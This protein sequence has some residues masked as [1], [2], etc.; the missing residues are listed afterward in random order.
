MC[1][2]Y[3]SVSEVMISLRLD[4]Q[5]HKVATVF[6]C[7]VFLLSYEELLLF[8][9]GLRHSH[10]CKKASSDVFQKLPAAYATA[11]FLRVSLKPLQL[12]PEALCFQVVHPEGTFHVPVYSIRYKR[13]LGSKD[14]LIRF[15]RLTV[16]AIAT[17]W[18]HLD[19]CVEAYN[20]DGPLHRD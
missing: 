19:W 20:R 3:D 13:S 2:S 6:V 4:H 1:V 8:V 7:H 5:F 10:D 17:S 9:S 15:W 16:N 18:C 11:R 12:W 14:E